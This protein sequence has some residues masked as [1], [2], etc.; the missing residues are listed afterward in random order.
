MGRNKEMAAE[1]FPEVYGGAPAEGE[2]TA[3]KGTPRR[4][5]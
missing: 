4:G 3:N 5:R 1:L 2:N